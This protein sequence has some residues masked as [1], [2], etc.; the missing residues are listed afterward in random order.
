MT[1]RRVTSPLHFDLI[2]GDCVDGMTHLHDDS[3]DLVVTS[4]PYNLGVHYGKYVDSK[5]VEE[6]LA[7]AETWASQIRRILKPTGSFF[8]NLGAA[9]S[10]PLLPHR[11]ALKMAELFVLQNT[12]HWVKSITVETKDGAPIS[13]GHFKP[14]NSDRF[15]NDCHEYLF[16]FTKAGNS[17]LCRLAVGVPYVDKTN[18]ARWAHTEGK[19]VRCR[20]N[21][22]FVP[23]KTIRDRVNQRPHPA[24]FPTALAEM[25]V[26]LAGC[27]EEMTM[28]DPF[29][30][31]GH[32]ALA[33]KACGVKKFI[34]FDIDSDY[35]AVAR[36]ALQD[37]P[38]VPLQLPLFP[39][40]Q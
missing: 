29:V 8:L 34:G 11:M 17:R 38:A 32:A 9:P 24:T 22:W 33:A 23:Y 18:I 16:H 35:L 13:V 39:Q 10:N 37:A 30:G 27:P 7:W 19:D 5:S 3:V 15:V 2:Q 6:Y 20:G 1:D 40:P 36:K 12:F 25:C 31:I 21:T 4:P 28:L 26:K 14:V